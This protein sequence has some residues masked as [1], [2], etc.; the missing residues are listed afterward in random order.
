MA[1]AETENQEYQDQ[2]YEDQAYE[3]QEYQD[4]QESG[5]EEYAATEES[6]YV[7]E[8]AE[9]DRPGLGGILRKPLVRI[10]LLSVGAAVVLFIV[11]NV[12]LSA[13]KSQR[14]KPI[15]VVV[16]PNAQLVTKNQQPRSDSQTYSTSDSVQQVLNFY[17]ERYRISN[18]EADGCK[19]IY[20]TSPNS[21]EPGKVSGRCSV[22]D[23]ML[24]VS[25]S[26]SIRIDHVK[27][28]D[29][30]GKTVILIERTWGG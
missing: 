11:A 15:D 10:L 17:I 27:G 3:A 2:V 13:M 18:L 22:S 8:Q 12:A 14:G 16:Y 20:W 26:L 6:E 29:G 25:Q 7:A 24:E 9:T 28:A 30:T 1:H 19:K 23:S 5:Q 21:E 4:S